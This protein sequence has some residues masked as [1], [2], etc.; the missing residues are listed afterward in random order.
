MKASTSP[1]PATRHDCADQ[2]APRERDPRDEQ[3]RHHDHAEQG[4]Q[5]E[6]WQH[7]ESREQAVVSKASRQ[8]GGVQRSTL[9]E[10]GDKSP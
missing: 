4:G 2:P 7:D 8:P 10:S 3:P 9:T 6:Q 1:S 5:G